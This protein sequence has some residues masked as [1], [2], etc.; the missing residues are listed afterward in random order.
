MEKR[1]CLRHWVRN[2]LKYT[3]LFLFL[4][5]IITGAAYCFIDNLISAFLK[6][7]A[8]LAGA[9]F[10]CSEEAITARKENKE[11]YLFDSANTEQMVLQAEIPL[12]PFSAYRIQFT[13]INKGQDGKAVRIYADLNQAESG[14]DHAAQQFYFEIFPG[15]IVSVDR[16]IYT[17]FV[18]PENGNIRF[19]FYTE[20]DFELGDITVHLYRFPATLIK[21]ALLFVF[22][23]LIGFSIWTISIS[24]IVQEDLALNN[25][26]VTRQRDIPMDVLKGIGV[27]FVILGHLATTERVGQGLWNYIYSFHMPM[28]FMISGYLAYGKKEKRFLSHVKHGIKKFGFL[29]QFYFLF[30]LDMFS[31][32]R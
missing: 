30:L 22:I 21:Y 19:V 10:S 4:L 18:P 5:T 16:M 31:Y 25:R 26:N 7:D 1:N 20:N 32:F 28:F 13:A 29:I 9:D 3:L 12:N 15:E 14:Y 23:G 6:G 24:G 8:L 27:I 11:V 17:T 2:N